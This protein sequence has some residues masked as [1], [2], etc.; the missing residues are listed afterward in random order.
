MG[1]FFNRKEKRNKEAVS[2][3]YNIA[4]YES[5]TDFVS[6]REATAFSA[7]D[8]IANS[9]AGLGFGVYDLDT[10]ELKRDHWLYQV[11]Q[12]P[13][14]E[15]VHSLFF[16]QLVKDWFDGGAFVYLFKNAEGKIVSFFRMN[17]KGV[18]ISRDSVTN[19]KI[20]NYNGFRYRADRV[21]HIPGTSA[22]DG[23]TGHSIFS[24]LPNVFETSLKLDAY[25]SNTFDQNMGK[26]LVID[27]TD[28][29]QDMSKEQQEQLRDSYVQRYAGIKNA[30][31]PIV[32]QGGIKFET[33]DT[34]T[35]S[36]QASELKSNREYQTLLI[37]EI[38]HVPQCLLR[39]D[40]L[41]NVEAI[42]TVY[43]NTAVQPIASLF[44][45]YL[46]TLLP[47][48]ERVRYHF[49][50]NYN[51]LMKTSLTTRID[52]Y[53]KQIM[54]GILSVDEVRR[55]ENL[56]EL[57]TDA[58]ETLFIPAN[59]MPLKDEVIESYMASA[60]LKQAE[61]DGKSDNDAPGVGDD[62]K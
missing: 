51:S 33:L 58:A 8:L 49:E 62:K 22:Y 4:D 29:F 9:V 50:F 20:F 42:Y 30:G 17:P 6:G 15:E 40:K 12:Q 27:A 61:L 26:R 39:G 25:V 48:E 3:P 31:K 13:N 34:G 44:E 1:L 60:K 11:I 2:K 38:F 55:K 14:L 7:I 19:E 28:A 57:G 53:T 59:L 41:D 54:N 21:L 56:P 23:K 32:K 47:A 52:S 18:T 24:E 36:N 5:S 43:T 16:K 37:S 46:N 10:H 35:S 45:E